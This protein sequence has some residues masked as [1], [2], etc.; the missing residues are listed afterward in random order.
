VRNFSL[1]ENETHADISTDVIHFWFAL[2]GK[3]LWQNVL[4]R[5]GLRHFITLPTTKDEPTVLVS[6]MMY[7]IE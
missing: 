7:S 3:M 4:E 6:H 5:C 2:E 1:E